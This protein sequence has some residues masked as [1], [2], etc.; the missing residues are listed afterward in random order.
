MAATILF[1]PL[2][3]GGR[4]ALGQLLLVV[5]AVGVAACWCLRQ[6]LSSDPIWVRSPALWLVLGVLG[7]VDLQIT[8]LPSSWLE[9]LS[10]H[11]YQLLPLWAP[12]SDGAAT[13]G[14]W[15][16]LSLAP[17]AT[18]D[19]FVV[20][21]AFGLLFLVVVQRVRRPGDVERFLKWIALATLIMAAFALVQFFFSNGKFFWC[22]EHPYST[23][24]DAVKGSFSNRNH[25]AHFMALGTAPLMWWI[26]ARWRRAPAAASAVSFGKT[27]ARPDA[28]IGLLAVG[29]AV[30]VFAA[31]LSLSR[32]GTAAML[33][34]ALTCL[35]IVH[36]GK[37]LHRK[38]LL[39][40]VGAAAL[41]SAC[42]LIY[43][44]QSVTARLEDFSSVEQLDHG[45]QRR[46]IWQADLAAMTDFPAAGA[47]L[48]SHV[49]LYPRYLPEDE[50]MQFQEYTHAENG[51]VQI[52]LEAGVPGVLLLAVTIG[53]CVWWCVPAFRAPRADRIALCFA[54]VAPGLVASAVHSAADFV[55]YVP[56]CMVT[57]VVLAA[58]ACRLR[59][60]ADPHRDEAAKR[61]CLPRT[62]WIAA[63]VFLLGIGVLLTQ[64]RLM[65]LRA[66]PSWHR[67]LQIA[68]SSAPLEQLTDWQ[69]LQSMEEELAAVVRDQPDH[70]QAHAQLAAVHLKMFDCAPQSGAMAMDVRQVRDAVLAS[71]FKSVAAMDQW[72][73]QAFGARRPHLDA[74]AWHARRALA[75]CPLGRT[76]RRKLPASIRH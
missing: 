39:A 56:G 64:N 18:R 1:V 66:E 46:K 72:L 33:L 47:G 67:Y 35:L 30:I 44:Y 41:A 73:S 6:G 37:R 43:G 28:R 25:F 26:Y 53:L 74:A 45:R 51:Y 16:T 71:R 23:T 50:G 38:M 59:Q 58:C 7:L 11:V 54:G 40:L 49:D 22:F 52:G 5:L 10:P 61:S 36:R 24:N 65:A 17:A 4:T 12:R 29:L 60:M 2:A 13:I 27:Q 75:S 32:G 34:A 19:A 55:W 9:W 14:L 42:L 69:T 21:M 70:A 62:G 63:G 20:V 8:P 31:V 15:N 68:R 76:L 57:P 48:G 3:M